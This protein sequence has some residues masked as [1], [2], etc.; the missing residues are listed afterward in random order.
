MLFF[1]ILLSTLSCEFANHR[2]GSQLKKCL[3]VRQALGT[4]KLWKVENLK[5]WQFENFENV[6]KDPWDMLNNFCFHVYAQKSLFKVENVNVFFWTAASSSS[7]SPVSLPILEL[8]KKSKY[9]HLHK[10]Q[11]YATSPNLW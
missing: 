4:W 11:D 8:K 7:P 2:A 10:M 3:K 5:T 1:D 9:F 6:K